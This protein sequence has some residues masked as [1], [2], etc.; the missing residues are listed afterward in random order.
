[1]S[2][3]CSELSFE[4]ML[5]LAV[6]LGYDGIEPRIA[7][8][9]AHGVEIAASPAIRRDTRR[10]AADA[11]VEI[12]CIASSCRFATPALSEEHMPDA[13]AAIDLAGDVG[14][15]M[16]RVFGGRLESRKDRPDAIEH[17]AGCLGRLADQ[18]ERR[19][20]TVCVETH[21]AW[22]EPD[23]VAAVMQRVDHPAIAV[24]W[25]IMHPVLTAGRTIEEAFETLRPWIRHV[26]VHDGVKDE[27]GKL[28]LEPIGD[29]DVDHRRALELLHGS[30]YD[31][32]ISGE[33]IEWESA[34][35]HLP[36]ELERLN[37]IEA[38][39]GKL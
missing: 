6:R 3:S 29:G 39:F 30:G 20:V 26:H 10:Q 24:N 11:G 5:D 34:D 36:R 8:N 35:V 2:F 32:H 12:C 14:A 18:A 38:G 21:D 4:Q 33:W 13:M 22:C 9:H 15:P 23:D 1:M 27:N 37:A 7:A 16:L 17:F 28:I 31:G 25:D 19:Q